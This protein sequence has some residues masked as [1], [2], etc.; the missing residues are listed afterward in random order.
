MLKSL[1]NFFI[2][3]SV[4]ALIGL[5]RCLS[6]E[7]SLSVGALVGRLAYRLANSVRR[8]TVAHM[9]LAFPDQS[10]S[11]RERLAHAVFE[12]LGRAAAEV[13]NV[14]KIR[15][16][17]DYVRLDPASRGVILNLLARGRGVIFVTGHIG[18][19]ELMARALAAEGFPIYA[20]GKRSYDERFTALIQKFRDQGNVKTIWRGDP[21]A[22][23]KMVAVMKENSILGLLL[24]Q[25]TR[26]QG[27]FVPFFDCPAHTPTAAA[28]LARKTGAAVLTGFNYREPEGG[29]RIICEEFIPVEDDEFSHAVVRDTASMTARIEAHI[30]AHPAE[31]VW[32]HRRWK[33]R[34]PNEGRA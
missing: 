10:V 22:F 16:L 13:V 25:D 1:K 23:E 4:R 11:D 24:D 30:R 15:D 28:V 32:M 8:D 5:L 7:R 3:W 6:W 34:P 20:I 26:V 12:H 2:Y 19:W 18:N 27:V 9:Q 14:H 31:W 29:L 33:T 21:D 17:L